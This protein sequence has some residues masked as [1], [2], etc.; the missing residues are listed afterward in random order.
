MK[1]VI[2]YRSI[3][4]FEGVCRN[5]QHAAR[6][7]GQ[8]ENDEVIYDP[9]PKYPIVQAQATEKIHGCFEKRT[10]VTLANGEH[11][12]ISKLTVGTYVLSF[13]TKT[14]EREAQRIT[15]VVN[16]KLS[17]DWCRLVFDEVTILCTKDHAFWTVN[18]GY[19]EAQNLSTEDIFETE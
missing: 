10:M 13:N 19:V 14:G 11:V 7:M 8:D 4:Q 18:R 12:P 3:E 5:V 2:A 9:N 16:Q 1:R 6:Y 15:S 17:K